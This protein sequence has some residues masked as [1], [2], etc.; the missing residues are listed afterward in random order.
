MP[1]VMRA[2]RLAATGVEVRTRNPRGGG[3]G[4]RRAGMRLE[5]GPAALRE[6]PR[7]PLRSLEGDAPGG[8]KISVTGPRADVPV[9]LT[10]LFRLPG[11]HPVR[12]IPARTRG[13]RRGSA[14][15]DR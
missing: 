4:P 7:T 12:G 6:R 15:T 11:A 14:T 8:G 10:A 13:P 2:C 5:G 1:P 9:L 3:H